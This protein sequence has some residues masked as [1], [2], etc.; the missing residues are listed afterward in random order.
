MLPD[1]ELFIEE[2]LPCPMNPNAPAKTGLIAIEP[3]RRFFRFDWIYNDAVRSKNRSKLIEVLLRL[4]LPGKK[5]RCM[6]DNILSE[7]R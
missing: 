2:H 7:E 4:Q 5:A 3:D 1:H 6:A